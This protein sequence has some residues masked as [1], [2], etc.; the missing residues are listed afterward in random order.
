[1]LRLN[2]R[3]G[4]STWRFG[5]PQWGYVDGGDLTPTQ[6]AAMLA[7]KRVCC[8]IHGY[9]V[10]EPDDA[11]AR[12][13]LHVEDCY[14]ELLCLKW[15]GSKWTLAFWLARIRAPKAGRML[16]EALGALD[17]AALDIEAHSLGCRVALEAIRYGLRCRNLVLAGAAVANEALSL[18]E[19]FGWCLANAT[20]VLVAWSHHD[21]VLAKPGR[22]GLFNNPLGLTGPEA[23]RKTLP[24]VISLDCSESVPKHSAYKSDTKTFLPAWRAIA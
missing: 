18:D 15:P 14:D 11:Y 13:A 22:L 5:A 2:I 19:T 24:H 23:G 9:N 6:A 16:A 17:C 1:M 4:E 8:L 7:G 10:K 3:C 12:I 21:D 20:R